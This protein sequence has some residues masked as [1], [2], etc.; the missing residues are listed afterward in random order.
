MAETAYKYDFGYE[1]NAAVERKKEQHTTAK[2][3]LEVIVN[4][5]ARQIARE[6]EVNKLA[7]KVAALLAV[8]IAVF[9]IFCYT[10]VL[11]A[12]VGYELAEKQT[13]LLVHQTKNQELKAKLN[14]LVAGV[15]IDKYAVEELGLVKVEADNEVYFNEEQGNKIIYSAVD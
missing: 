1:K 9:S 7:F 14:S 5:L 2:P 10:L 4:P 11:K 12:D 15:D 6:K 8:A 3:Q 13:N